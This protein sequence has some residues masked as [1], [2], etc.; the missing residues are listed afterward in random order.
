MSPETSTWPSG[1]KFCMEVSFDI[2]GGLTEA[3]FEFCSGG[4]AKGYSGALPWEDKNVKKFFSQILNFF[5]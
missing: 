2:M 4:R 3:I 5:A 1:L